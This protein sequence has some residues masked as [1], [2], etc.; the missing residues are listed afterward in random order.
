MKV[1]SDHKSEVKLLWQKNREE[2]SGDK[3][4]SSVLAVLIPSEIANEYQKSR[5]RSDYTECCFFLGL[6]FLALLSTTCS[7]VELLGPPCVRRALSIVY[8][9]INSS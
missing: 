5:S 1:L 7:R 9:N 2:N 3:P 6:T 4:G 8:L